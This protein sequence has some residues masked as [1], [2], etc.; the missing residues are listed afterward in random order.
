MLACA[1]AGL[2][3]ACSFDQ[4]Q[5]AS[6]DPSAD[7]SASGMGVV[8][9]TGQ[10]GMGSIHA[11]P[12]MGRM[13]SQGFAR[14]ADHGDL[15]GYPDE[16]VV[17]REGPYT[18]HRADISEAH[19]LNAIVDGVLSLTTPSGEQLRFQYDRHVEHDSGD[20]TW[21]GHIVGGG[22]AQDAILTFGMGAVFGTIT[23]PGKAP[24]DLAMADGAAWL[25]ETDLAARAAQA[26]A[27]GL[28][29]H[30]DF[31]VPRDLPSS[32]GT[33]AA[34]IRMA[35]ALPGGK[36]TVDVLVGYTTGF[37]TAQMGR[38]GI[39]ANIATR[40]N[41][42]VDVTN[43][44]YVNSQV[45]AEVRLVHTM[46]VDYTDANDN[47]TALQSLTGSDG[48]DPVARD[49]G[50]QPLYAA[51]E[52]YGADLV[53]LVRDFQH[54]EA[55][56]CG[57]AW[58]VGGGLN[59]I[60]DEYEA[61][62]MS[63][64]SDGKDGG[65]GCAEVTFAHELGHNMGLAHDV[66][67]SK[68]DDGVLDNPDDYGHFAYSFGYRTGPAN[69]NFHTVMA[70][71]DTG[72][73]ISYYVFSNPDVTICGG[74]P[75]GVEGQADNARALRDTIPVIAT[76]RATV[77][78][79]PEPDITSRVA[80]DVNADG[81]ADVLWYNAATGGFEAW[82]MDG[83]SWTYGGLQSAGSTNY[84][85]AGAGDFNGDGRTDLVWRD[86]AE[87]EVW[88]WL[89]RPDGLNDIVFLRNV[90]AA[91][92][93]AGVADFNGDGR[94]DVFWYNASQGLTQA[95]YMDGSTWVYGPMSNPITPNAFSIADIGD[96]DGDG[97]ADIVW[98]DNAK[99][100][101]WAW[102]GQAQG[103][104]SIHYLRDYPPGWSI[105]GTGDANADGRQDIFWRN[106]A[107]GSMETW[108]MDG[109]SWAYGPAYGV[110]SQYKVAAIDDFN[111]DGR[112][113]IFWH[114]DVH[115]W[116]WLAQEN[117]GY[118]IAYLRTY[119]SGWSVVNTPS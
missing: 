86:N 103:S 54:P 75:C 66:E 99:T 60:Y 76:F 92:N 111:G 64:V 32:G 56:S 57:V 82:Y 72:N 49:P 24:L 55:V 18:W 114:D 69:G 29:E 89:A 112:V 38:A 73:E 40:L 87:T 58:L 11:A 26:A 79:E 16:P 25:V 116:L 43:E 59:P 81:R 101:L 23:Q 17:R 85:I 28:Y 117:G 22:Q 47:S 44:S 42:L 5:S 7:P 30:P 100:Q 2:A 34:P 33:G 6:A 80:R 62:G 15:V 3:S 97:L 37:A 105:V 13:P 63:V 65:F 21:I 20:W 39:R 96:F 84:K 12:A 41:H 35:A 36:T 98:H 8:A 108:L 106:A 19:A 95:W 77:V 93:I 90:P 113:D 94:D 48:S 78:P 70:Y 10:A 109:A 83:A 119:P 110:A 88:I 45:N 46:E 52:T 74:L 27:S 67:T 104:F 71:P 4:G 50:L 9:L 61:Y 102:I 14:L 107:L 31:L 118:S 53:M 51:R 115:A 68:G 1:F 91:W